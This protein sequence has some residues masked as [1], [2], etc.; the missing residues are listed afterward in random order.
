MATERDVTALIITYRRSEL[1]RSTLNGLLA[2]SVIPGRILVS[3]GSG[4]GSACQAIATM[5]SQYPI[6][7]VAAPR[8]GTITGN[9]NHLVNCCQTPLALLM[10]DDIC[11]HPRFIER[12]LN[13][14]NGESADLVTAFRSHLSA[15]AWFTFRGHWRRRRSNEPQAV[16]PTTLLAPTAVLREVPFDENLVYG[17]EEEDFSLRLG[18]R[19]CVTLLDCPSED[20]SARTSVVWSSAEKQRLGESSRV[21]VSLKRYWGSRTTVAQFLAAEVAANVGRRRRPLPRALVPHQW[22]AVM[23][24]A[25]RSKPWPWNETTPV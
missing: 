12:A 22:R 15:E 16:S 4:D 2:S 18:P 21:F 20:L 9:R 3:E 5:V 8:L 1:L 23:M 11:I 25:F 24:R 14:L 7:L 10:D 17:Y 19:R 6:E 13:V